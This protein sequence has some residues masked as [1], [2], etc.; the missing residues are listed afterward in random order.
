MYVLLI[1]TL[2][3]K[4]RCANMIICIYNYIAQTTKSYNFL[5]EAKEEKLYLYIYVCITMHITI[6]SLSIHKCMFLST[7]ERVNER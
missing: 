6:I 7:V 5:L 3:N 1:I 2:Y 4:V